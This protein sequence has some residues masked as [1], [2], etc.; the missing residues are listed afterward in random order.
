MAEQNV[1]LMGDSRLREVSKSV[2]TEDIKSK[3]I[4]DL[5]QDLRDTAKTTPLE[6]GF[7]T[8]GLSAPQ[9]G[10][11]KRIFVVISERSKKGEPKFDVY[12]NPEIDY[13]NTE[14]VEDTES[15][16]STP[17]ICGRVKRYDSIKLTYYDEEGNKKREKFNGEYA[18]FIQHEADHLDGVLWI[19]RVE[20]TKTISYC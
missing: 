20:D 6:E 9:I 7:I 8:V 14:M 19:D 3:E 5:I 15:C 16:L 17:G 4:Q 18:V 1:L 12:I 11:Q 13:Q 2:D 10:V